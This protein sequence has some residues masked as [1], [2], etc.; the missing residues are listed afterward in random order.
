MGKTGPKPKPTALKILHG[1]R[2]TARLNMDEP[3]PAPVLPNAPEDVAPE[4][5]VVWD[6]T[7]A[8]LEVMGIA[9]SCDMEAL[10]CFCEA[11]VLHRR[12]S[13]ILRDEPLLVDGRQGTMVRNPAIVIQRDAA[14]RVRKFAEQFG[15]TP[16]ARSSIKASG[17]VVGEP[18]TNPFEGTQTG[19]GG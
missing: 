9:F 17:T 11:V 14:D 3:L 19:T 10:L 2:H 18:G 7:L 12:S 8:E 4:V 5:R 13:R 15:L 1:E 6:R 16:S